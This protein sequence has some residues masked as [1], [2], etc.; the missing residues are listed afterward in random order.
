MIT[1][2]TYKGNIL[3]TSTIPGETKEEG[4]IPAHGNGSW[5]ISKDRYITCCATLDTHS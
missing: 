4:Y 2:I 1:N 5:Q 3:A